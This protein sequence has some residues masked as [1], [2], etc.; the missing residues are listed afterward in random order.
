VTNGGYA[1]ICYDDI[2]V[3]AK[4][5]GLALDIVRRKVYYADAGYGR[6]GELSM[7]GTGH[8]IIIGDVNM[9]PRGMVYDYQNRYARGLL[10]LT[11][12]QSAVCQ[13]LLKFLVFLIDC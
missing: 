10:Q 12:L 9:K 5:D 3:T 11:A 4:F 8:R 13:L 2:S 6:I 1:K 7:D